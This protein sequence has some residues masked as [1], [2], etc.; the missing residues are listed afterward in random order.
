VP[1]RQ[2][3]EPRGV[4][5]AAPDKSAPEIVEVIRSLTDPD[6]RREFIKK[7]TWVLSA[8]AAFPL[9]FGLPGAVGQM[10]AIGVRAAIAQNAHDWIGA[11][12]FGPVIIC[13]FPVAA[14]ALQALVWSIVAGLRPVFRF[15]LRHFSEETR[16]LISGAV[17]FAGVLVVVGGLVYSCGKDGYQAALKHASPSITDADQKTIAETQ[18]AANKQGLAL[19]KFSATADALL[20]DLDRTALKVEETKREITQTMVLFDRQLEATKVAQ[21]NLSTLAEQ[22]REIQNR[23]KELELILNGKTPITQEYLDRSGRDSLWQ[24]AIIGVLTSLVAAYLFLLPDH[25]RRFLSRRKR[26]KVTDENDSTQ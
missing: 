12:L 25:L 13:T 14:Y 19:Q 23:A 4:G 9:V 16:K 15:A 7:T 26:S 3:E 8:A 21:A 18:E 17:K 1:D 10:L 6:R 20:K 22:Q 24:G 5:A 2:G 11:L